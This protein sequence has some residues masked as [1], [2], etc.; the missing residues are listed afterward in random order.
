MTAFEF[1]ADKRSDEF[2]R[3]IARKMMEKFGIAKDEAIVRINARFGGQTLRRFA[4]LRGLALG[5]AFGS[6][7]ADP[8]NQAALR[9]RSLLPGPWLWTDDTEMACSTFAVLG[10]YGRI[11][12]DAQAESFARHHDFYRRYGPGTNRILRLMS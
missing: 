7:Y 2:L 3:S 4:S 9:D 10:R 12:Q 6:C 5:D 1:R 11:E 8:I